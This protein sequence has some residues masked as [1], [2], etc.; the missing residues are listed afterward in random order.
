VVP[1]HRG[2]RPGEDL[3]DVPVAR[4]LRHRALHEDHQR[5]GAAARAEL[6]APAAAE[7]HRLQGR[8]AE[9]DPDAREHWEDDLPVE[10]GEEKKEEEGE[11]RPKASRKRR[12]T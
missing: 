9:P 3:D 2:Q 1:Q 12:V 6:L 10:R 8:D 7:P 11:E 5:R 4:E